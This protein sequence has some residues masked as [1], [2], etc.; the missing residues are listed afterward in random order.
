MDEEEEVEELEDLPDCCRDRERRREALKVERD[1][2]RGA[3]RATNRV[4]K[5]KLND[6]LSQLLGPLQRHFLIPPSQ[7]LDPNAV[8]IAKK[9]K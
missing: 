3:L 7:H 8:E 4:S 1:A 9:G 6:H 5:E 2:L